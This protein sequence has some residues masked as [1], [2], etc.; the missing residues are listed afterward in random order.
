MVEKNR[1][2]N[3]HPKK[4]Y[5]LLELGVGNASHRIRWRDLDTDK[6]KSLRIQST[7]DPAEKM[8]EIR[9]ELE[10]RLLSGNYDTYESR[11]RKFIDTKERLEREK[12]NGS[13][14]T[15]DGKTIAVYQI[16]VEEAELTSTTA[17]NGA[18]VIKAIDDLIDSGDI[19]KANELRRVLNRS[20]AAAYKLIDDRYKSKKPGRLDTGIINKIGSLARQLDE[21]YERHGGEEY[22]EDCMLF[23]KQLSNKFEEWRASE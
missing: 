15:K 2:T 8:E 22:R 17:S 14:I 16:A 1:K 4:V 9:R 21:K 13:R 11:I 18:P 19:E 10:D 20:A 5:I 3:S 23:L 7:E 6:M 12:K